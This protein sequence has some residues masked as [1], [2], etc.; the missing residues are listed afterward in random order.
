M[1]KNEILVIALIAMILVN[2]TSGL[3]AG[4]GGLGAGKRELKV[5]S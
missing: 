5:N 3:V 1:M 2:T 4:G